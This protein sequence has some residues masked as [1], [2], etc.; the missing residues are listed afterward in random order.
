MFHTTKALQNLL[1][2]ASQLRDSP[3]YSSSC[4]TSSSS[5][6]SCGHIGGSGRC[7]GHAVTDAVVVMALTIESIEVVV[8]VAPVVGAPLS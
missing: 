4:I 3:C 6:R 7:P 1:F 5:S 2:E 8:V